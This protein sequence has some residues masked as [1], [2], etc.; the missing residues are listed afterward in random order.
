MK[1][2]SAILAALICAALGCYMLL[3]MKS[4][5]GVG[6]VLLAVCIALPIPFTAGVTTL[7]T[8]LVVIVPVVLDVLKGG[9]R[10]TDPPADTPKD[11]AAG[12]TTTPDQDK[13]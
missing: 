13:P 5:W 12:A 7:K 3:V 9:S 6:L 4:T 10:R 2:L 1:I 11:A 8:N